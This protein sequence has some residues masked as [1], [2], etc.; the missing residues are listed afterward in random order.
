[1]RVYLRSILLSLPNHLTLKRKFASKV[2]LSVWRLTTSTRILVETFMRIMTN[3]LT[4]I[5]ASQGARPGFGLQ[6][7]N[8]L[9]ALRVG[10]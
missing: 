10:A 1:M 4:Y 3:S 8:I 5:A 9:Q 6:N 2:L 7:E